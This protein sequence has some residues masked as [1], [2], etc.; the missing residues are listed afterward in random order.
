MHRLKLGLALGGGTAWAA[1]RYLITSTGQIT[2]N[3]LRSLRGYRGYR[4]FRGTNGTNV[5]KGATGANAATT[6]KEQIATG[7]I[8]AN[9]SGSGTVNGPAEATDDAT[10]VIH[11]NGP[12][13]TDGTAATAT[14]WTVSWKTTTTAVSWAV[15]ATCAAP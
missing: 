4:G 6:I 12:L 14:G 1:H 10:A 3:V 11:E 8:A 13:P 2:P 15:F 7:K 5:A 9:S